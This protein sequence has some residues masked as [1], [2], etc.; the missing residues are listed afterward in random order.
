MLV[1]TEIWKLTSALSSFSVCVSS[2]SRESEKP[3]LERDVQRSDHSLF[4]PEKIIKT[5]RNIQ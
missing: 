1:K 2:G 3:F 4:S 5:F